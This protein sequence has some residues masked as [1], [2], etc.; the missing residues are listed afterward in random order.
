MVYAAYLLKTEERR[1][2]RASVVIRYFLSQL[3]LVSIFQMAY[4]HGG[5]R[6]GAGR[7]K[8][9]ANKLD[10]EARKKAADG[11]M[12]PLEFMLNI[13]RDEEQDFGVRFDAAKAAAPYVHA[14]LSTIDQ[15][16]NRKTSVEDLSNEELI[17]MIREFD[18]ADTED[19]E[20]LH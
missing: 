8:G 18:E 7:K 15:T 1:S 17:S 13:M 10:Q 11:G 4:G 20:K 9:S 5:K 12:L 6:P 14:K 19:T 16:I 2:M 3:D